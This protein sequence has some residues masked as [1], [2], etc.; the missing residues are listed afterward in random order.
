MKIKAF[1]LSGLV[2]FVSAPLNAV[3]YAEWATMDG[4]PFSAS[5]DTVTPELSRV[6]I[7]PPPGGSLI[8][9]GGKQSCT[10]GLKT[11]ASVREVCG[12][13]ETRLMPLGYERVSIF[14]EDKDSDEECNIFQNGDAVNGAGVS[15]YEVLNS[16]A[17]E[18]GTTQ[19]IVSYP[20]SEQYPCH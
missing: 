3:P 6:P 5:Q 20:P 16:A 13:Y 17:K 12:F 9:V 7:P 11:K 2:I 18:N 1:L 19:V 8:S 4:V 15:V 10:V 14:G